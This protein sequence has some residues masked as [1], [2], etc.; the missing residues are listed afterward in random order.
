MPLVYQIQKK[1]F[2]D[3]VLTGDGACLNEGRWNPL[4][5]P[6]VYT[7]TTPELALLE[8]LVHLDGTPIRDLPPF[9]RISIDVPDMVEEFSIVELPIGWDGLKYPDGLPFFLLPKLTP[10]YPALAFS[11][12][13][14]VLKNSP[15][16]HILINPLHP[17][18][19]QVQVVEVLA[20]ELDERLRK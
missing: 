15:S 20:H 10:V 11:L 3:L 1:Q 16:R 14:V 6:L 19:S 13:S 4:G 5:I 9:V 2:V 7:S 12:P 8:T 18:M 17:Q